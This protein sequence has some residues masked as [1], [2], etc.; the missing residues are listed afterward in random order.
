MTSAKAPTIPKKGEGYA[1]DPYV[2]KKL[3]PEFVQE[4]SRGVDK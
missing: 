4:K 3:R 1:T 2:N